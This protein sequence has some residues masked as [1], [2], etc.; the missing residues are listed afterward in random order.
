M[1]LRT[2]A[3]MLCSVA[4]AAHADS[5]FFDFDGPDSP[6]YTT[7]PFALTRSGLTARFVAAGLAEFTV[8][9]APSFATLAGNALRAGRPT[10]FGG[11]V[12]TIELSA[13][14]TSVDLV[15]ALDD[16]SQTAVLR[17]NLMEGGTLIGSTSASGT[18]PAGFLYP[19]GELSFSGAAFDQV[20][21]SA[22][23]LFAV[24]DLRLEPAVPIPEPG[25]DWLLAIGLLA[26][27]GIAR[28]RPIE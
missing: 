4:L 21:L 13:P 7:T 14:Q 24:D 15:F 2:G 17:M 19:E 3:A 11:F 6:M 12:L 22:G 26:V 20:A 18:I 5:A 8:T 23:L 16:P 10:A 28:R 9:A 1:F 25:T 27:G